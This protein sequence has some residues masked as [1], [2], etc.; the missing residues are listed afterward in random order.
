MTT[1]ALKPVRFFNHA[2]VISPNRVLGISVRPSVS[3]ISLRPPS[4]TGS[5]T[6]ICNYNNSYINNSVVSIDSEVTGT[7]INSGVNGGSSHSLPRS[8]FDL[9]NDDRLRGSPNSERYQLVYASHYLSRIFP[10]ELPC[11]LRLVTLVY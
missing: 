9:K 11:L 6:I 3:Q 8:R 10:Q 2:P 5:L 7:T 4:P 1:T